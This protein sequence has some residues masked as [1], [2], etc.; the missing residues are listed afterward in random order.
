MKEKTVAQQATIEQLKKEI[1]EM[2]EGKSKI[3]TYKADVE[4]NLRAAD[5]NV[6]IIKN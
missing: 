6:G 1:K 5:Y 3:E 4:Y 2:E